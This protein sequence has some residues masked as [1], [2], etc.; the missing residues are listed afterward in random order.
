MNRGFAVKAATPA[1]AER[2]SVIGTRTFTEAFGHLYAPEDLDSFLGSD[3]SVAACEKL[4]ADP[5]FRAFLVREGDADIAYAVAGPDGL[6]RPEGF[7]P[8]GELKRLYVDPHAQGLRLGPM[9]MSLAFS[10]L[11]AEGYRDVYI[12]VYT[13]NFRAQ[14]VY[15]KAGFGPICQYFYMVGKHAD[16]EL[17]LHAPMEKI[18]R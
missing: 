13:D 2:L 6:P 16:P 7:S 17:I 3:H 1:D 18:P 11:R 9:L 15:A 5:R 10:F 4:L 8:G 12:S 14:K